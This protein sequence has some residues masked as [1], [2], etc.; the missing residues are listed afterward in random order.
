MLKTAGQMREGTGRFVEEV[1][2]SE[3]V[4]HRICECRFAAGGCAAAGRVVLRVGEAVEEESV[5]G[6]HT[7]R[8]ATTLARLHTKKGLYKP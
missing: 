1:A 2:A 7:T 3:A 4:S 5:A 8:R 6:R